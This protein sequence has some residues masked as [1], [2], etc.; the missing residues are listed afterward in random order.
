MCM[1]KQSYFFNRLT[2][3]TFQKPSKEICTVKMHTAQP[4]RKCYWCTQNANKFLVRYQIVNFFNIAIAILDFYSSFSYRSSIFQHKLSLLTSLLNILHQFCT[5]I[6]GFLS[7]LLLIKLSFLQ[8]SQQRESC[9]SFS[10]LKAIKS[11][12]YRQKS[13]NY[14]KLNEEK[15]S[16]EMIPKMRQRILKAIT[17]Y[18]AIEKSL[19]L[20][21]Q[22]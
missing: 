11:Y 17:F 12:C 7:A 19:I 6:H 22:Y 8:I 21:S 20:P 15:K 4:Q 14:R 18:R 1:Q 10:I 5:F 2:L 13:D 16:K 3:W 9:C